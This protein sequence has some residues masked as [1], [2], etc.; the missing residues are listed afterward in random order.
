MGPFRIDRS[1]QK[2][3]AR[4]ADAHDTAIPTKSATLG[5]M[6]KHVGGQRA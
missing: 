4:M 5:H 3:I 1:T 6:R 2:V